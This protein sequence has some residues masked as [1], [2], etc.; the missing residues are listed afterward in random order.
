MD[1]VCVLGEGS[2]CLTPW[3][4][5]VS[6]EGIVWETLVGDVGGN[7]WQNEGSFVTACN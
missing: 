6:R 1:T 5:T 7:G 4:V 3:S 2:I